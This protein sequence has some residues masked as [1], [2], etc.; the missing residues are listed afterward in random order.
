MTGV[1]ADRWL[2]TRPEVELACVETIARDE[3]GVDG[4]LVELGS[5]QDRN[6]RISDLTD[7][8]VLKV[9][10]PETTRNII[11]LQDQAAKCLNK[12]G[13]NTPS[14]R[15]PKNSPFP[16]LK[17]KD[18]NK[19]EVRAHDFIAGGTLDSRNY[20]DGATSERMGE[21]AGK[22]VKALST[23][24][25]E[26]GKRSIQWELRNA[27]KVVRA[28]GKHL[29]EHEKVL[30][31]S[32]SLAANQIVANVA[33]RLPEQII[34]G[35]ITCDNVIQDQNRKLWLIDF[36]D[37][38]ESWRVSEL[39]V[40]AADIYGR[41]GSIAHVVRT[42]QGF[43]KYVPLTDDEVEVLWPLVI[44][45]GAGLVVSGRSQLS[46]DP[47]NSYAH[48]R[49]DL[50]WQVFEKAFAVDT[51]SAT[52]LLRLAAGKPH[53]KN[54]D[55]AELVEGF[56]R[57]TILDFSITSR[58]LDR[59]CWLEPNIEDELAEQANEP[60]A[61]ARFGEA[62]LTRTQPN[63]RCE[64][65]TRARG[66]QI[67]LTKGNQL[68]AP[69]AGFVSAT[70]STVKI[71][72]A[73]L[74][75]T[76]TGCQPGPVEE[77]IEHGAI[78]GVAADSNIRVTLQWGTAAPEDFFG[79]PGA[80]YSTES[81]LDPSVILG[82]APSPD[83]DV[84]RVDEQIR[85][86]AAMGGASERYYEDPPVIERGWRSL[87]VD[88]TGRAYLDMVNNVSAIGHSNPKLADRVQRQ[89]N[90]LNTNSRF[91][92]SAYAEF[93]EKLLAKSPHPSLDTVIPV[94]S[95]SEALDLAIRLAQ[96]ATGRQTIMAAREGYHGWTMA[97]D[98]VST[99]A[100]DNPT[101][102]E[103]RPAWVEI[104]DA[105]NPYRGKYRG[106]DSGPQYAADVTHHLE[107]L[108]EDGRLPAAFLSEPVLGNAG[109]II[110]PEG[111]LN[112]V[113][114]EIRSSGGLTIADEVQVGY[115]RLGE[116]FWATEM[117]GVIPDIIATAK[118]AG[119]AYPVG[120]LITR[121]EIVEALQLEG[122]FFSSAGGAPASAVAASTVLDEIHDKKLQERAKQ[123]GKVLK[124]KLLQLADKHKLIGAVHG[125][126]L[127]IG[128]ELV[129]DQE[130]LEPAREKT[131]L[132]CDRLLD[133]GIIMQATSE[134]QNVLK[135][136]PPMVITLDEIEMFISALDI[137]LDEIA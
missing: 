42:V 61:I 88:T 13:V 91:L 77:R 1:Q 29:T 96:I 71:R 131:A 59:G 74:V 89:L 26:A 37:V 14:S 65:Y 24:S 36:G 135:V 38:A 110:P 106:P 52:A 100:F 62:R 10:H 54:L 115:G 108:R 78:F 57:H 79:L 66:V 20:L 75:L 8:L 23:F 104:V 73:G 28:L 41:T 132:V 84:L 127:Y 82:C 97:S 120:A 19:A 136:K 92:Y 113:Y 3:F 44:L 99:S 39:A 68:R 6:F 122:M 94:N 70:D 67:W 2:L 69:F 119:N 80:E 76:V 33:N 128:V 32:A 43:V 105:P 98:A 15:V 118:A 83:P 40:T 49:V 130:T 87:L 53:R 11:E 58:D 123:N 114:D 4:E 46:I 27:D 72:D 47:Q 134:R 50:E 35:D 109:G 101:A 63:V 124:Q 21:L 12:H 125:S 17:T 81:N 111:Y 48:E 5:Q 18:G 7:E 9:F 51:R 112:Q 103:S 129:L 137:V 45:R 93:T 121:S 95:G 64:S 22:S 116:N 30:C 34:H 31:D 25:H 102:L 16:S 55:Y 86:D 117:L 60:I 126:G 90:L 133:L 56:R 85:R 107:R